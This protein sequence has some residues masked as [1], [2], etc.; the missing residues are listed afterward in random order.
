MVITRK[1]PVKVVP[2]QIWADKFPGYKGRTVRVI[3]GGSTQATVEVVTEAEAVWATESTIGCWFHVL[4]DDRGLRGYRLVS[5]PEQVTPEA[6]PEPMND[7]RLAE[8]YQIAT[9][10]GLNWDEVSEMFDEIERLRTR[11]ADLGDGQD[12]V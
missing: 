3:K 4:F 1:P 5:E 6:D 10:S 7:A 2:G 9:S 8:L 12:G 11:L